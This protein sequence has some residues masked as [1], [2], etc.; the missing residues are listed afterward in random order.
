[1][2]LLNNVGLPGLIFVLLVLALYVVTVQMAKKRN[3]SGLLWFVI[4]LV[5]TP[6]LAILLL[7]AIGAKPAAQTS[8]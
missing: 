2:K 6:L 4:A 8:G 3:R 1:M 5:G 7:A